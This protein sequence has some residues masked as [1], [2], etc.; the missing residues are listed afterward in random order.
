M[1]NN[2][3]CCGCCVLILGLR[4]TIKDIPRGDGLASSEYDD[5]DN[6]PTPI[7]NTFPGTSPGPC[8]SPGASP[9]AVR[10]KQPLSNWVLVRF[11]STR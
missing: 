8:A 7:P 5:K 4:L 6:C 11:T 9:L 10:P 3:C 1:D 2:C